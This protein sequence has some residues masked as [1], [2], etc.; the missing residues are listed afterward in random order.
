MISG[1]A[2]FPNRQAVNSDR[3]CNGA[4][5]INRAQNMYK[6]SLLWVWALEHLRYNI[7]ALFLDC[8]IKSSF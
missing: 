2:K 1:K 5:I 8:G 4:I 6:L 7:M 3:K